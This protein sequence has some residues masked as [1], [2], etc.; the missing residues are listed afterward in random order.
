MADDYQIEHRDGVT[1]IR[2]S[3]RPSF[4]QVKTALDDVAAHHPYQRRLWDLSNI[5]F[6]FTQ[7]EIQRIADYGKTKFVEPNR[8]AIVAPGDLAFGEMREFEVYRAQPG[9]SQARVFRTEQEALE[10][11]GQ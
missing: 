9:H 4:A 3:S 5:K 7:Q 11:L 1:R 6:D 8:M 2:F 10:W